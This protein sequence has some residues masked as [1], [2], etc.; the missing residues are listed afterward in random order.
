[1]KICIN[2]KKPKRKTSFS[3]NGIYL[4]SYCKKCAVKKSVNWSKNNPEKNRA[5]A[6]RYCRK[7]KELVLDVSGT[8]YNK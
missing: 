5:K 2:C 6:L 8:H 1:M 4:Y 3:K 7:K